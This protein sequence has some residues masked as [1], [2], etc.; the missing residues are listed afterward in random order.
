MIVPSSPGSGT[1]AL[2]RVMARR[3][4]ESLK[5]S[6]VVENRPGG[7]GVIG[8]NAVLKAAPDGYTILYTTASNMVVA[9]A[10]IKPISQEARKSLVP[11]R[12]NCGGWGCCC[13]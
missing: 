3:L 9:P 11:I 7:S 8:T 10:V 13:W 1:D 4:S 6:V 5:Q 12:A 2:A